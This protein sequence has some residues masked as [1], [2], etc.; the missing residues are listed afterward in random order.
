MI[1]MSLKIQTTF[2]KTI[3]RP[4]STLTQCCKTTEERKCHT[5]MNQRH[6]PGEQEEN[7]DEEEPPSTEETLQAPRI[8]KINPIPF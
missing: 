3:M 7:D 5:W 1:L 4:G 2:P 8:K 6:D